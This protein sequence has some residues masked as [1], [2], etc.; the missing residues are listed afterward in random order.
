MLYFQS[1]SILR[2]RQTNRSYQEEKLPVQPAFP[3]ARDAILCASY[4]WRSAKPRLFPAGYD[5]IFECFVPSEC[6]FQVVSPPL[7]F[8]IITTSVSH[9]A[10]AADRCACA[11][12]HICSL[13]C[14]ISV[15]QCRFLESSL[16]LNLIS[17]FLTSP[18]DISPTRLKNEVL[19]SRIM[20]ALLPSFYVQA[21]AANPEGS[22]PK[23]WDTALEKGVFG[24]TCI[25]VLLR[26]LS[27]H[28]FSDNKC[29]T[30]PQLHASHG[31]RTTMHS[32][33][34]CHLRDFYTCKTLDK[35]W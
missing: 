6:R 10:R 35:C 32:L 26:F 20:H 2:Y 8:P 12:I 33:Q 28:N 29:P 25:Q 17:S 21:V 14:G 1:Y 5:L 30:Y 18:E 4:T 22:W 23:I 31:V 9:R 13:W 34:I 24:T 3:A 7:R 27:L 11:Y 16:Q 15:R 19:L